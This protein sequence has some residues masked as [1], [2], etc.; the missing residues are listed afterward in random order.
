MYIPQPF[1]ESRTE[2]L[3]QFIRR[4]PLATLIINDAE[5]IAADHIPLLLRAG[6]GPSGKLL[7]HVAR[8]NPLWQKAGDGIP[9][10][11]VF[12]GIDGYISPNG[13]ASKQETGKVVPT[14]NYEVVHVHGKVRAI[15]DPAALMDVLQALTYAHEADQ[16]AP[17]R[18]ADA[19]PDY[20]E[21]LLQA[22][23]GIEVEIE[24]IA[25]KAKLSQNQPVSNQKSLIHALQGCD[26]RASQE[27]AKAIQDRGGAAV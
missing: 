1:K 20:I 21:H 4:H 7:G 10:L 2:V 18:I 5:G 16:P 24:R 26:D 25:G 13:Y 3:H 6:A 23:V 9:C 11:L 27:M 8:S 22:I 15:D 19:P 14:W 17:W 12:H